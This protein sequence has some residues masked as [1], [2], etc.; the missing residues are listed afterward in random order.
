MKD[1]IF[2]IVISFMLIFTSQCGA[3]PSNEVIVIDPTPNPN[4]RRELKMLYNPVY[5][6]VCYYVDGINDLECLSID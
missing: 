4:Y 1:F 6:D 3:Q 2:G 5:N